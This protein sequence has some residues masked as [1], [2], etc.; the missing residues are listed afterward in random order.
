MRILLIEDDHEVS[1]YLRKSLEEENIRVTVRADGAAGLHAA[2]LSPFDVIVLDVMLPYLNGLD[3]TRTLRAES[4]GTPILLLTARDAPEDIVAGLDAGA[5]DYL[6]KPF[7]FD[8]LLAK[9]RARTRLPAGPPSRFRV[10]DLELDT[11]TRQVWRDRKAV[12]LTRTEFIILECLMRASGAVVPRKE[13]MQ[14]VWGN[15]RHVQNNLDVFIAF[16]RSKVEDSARRPLIHTIRGV[17]Y[18]LR[19][20]DD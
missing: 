1:D 19:E 2:R 15:G 20:R 8:V 12:N 4:V 16:L 3:V 9:L 5:D 7:S 6:T 17:G 14:A 18:L 10:A 13:L 11:R